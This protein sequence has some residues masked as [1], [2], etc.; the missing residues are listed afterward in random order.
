MKEYPFTELG[1]FTA[2]DIDRI[3]RVM[4]GQTFMRFDIRS[5]NCA[6]NHVLIIR[7]DYDATEAEIKSFFLGAALSQIGR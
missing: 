2:S 7:T 6:G 3:K 4:Q 1:Y 5:A